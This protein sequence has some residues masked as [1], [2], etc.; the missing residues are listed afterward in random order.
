MR[1]HRGKCKGTENHCDLSK[2]LCVIICLLTRFMHPYKNAHKDIYL[3]HFFPCLNVIEKI[4]NPL[5]C[6]NQVQT[7]VFQGLVAAD[8]ATTQLHLNNFMQTHDRKI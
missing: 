2:D 3:R 8:N 7:H 1:I 5:R 4:L 6:K